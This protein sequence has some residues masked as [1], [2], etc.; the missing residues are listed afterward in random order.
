MGD[1][2]RISGACSY[3]PVT[4]PSFQRREYAPVDIIKTPQKGFGLRATDDIDA[5]VLS[6]HPQS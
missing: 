6:I 3:G 5:C 4:D 2:A 1:T